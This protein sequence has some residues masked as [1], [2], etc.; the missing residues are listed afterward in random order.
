MKVETVACRNAGR[1]PSVEWLDT[2][3]RWGVASGTV[4]RA[5]T[6]HP[7]V[8]IPTGAACSSHRKLSPRQAELVPTP[9]RIGFL[10]S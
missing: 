10:L 2:N 6:R 1:A 9:E 8:P 3:G 7:E 4:S 5:N